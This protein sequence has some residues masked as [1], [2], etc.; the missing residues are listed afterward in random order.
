MTPT[1][2]TISLEDSLEDALMKMTT[3]AVLGHE[4]QGVNPGAP[5]SCL[6]ISDNHVGSIL[7]DS[8]FRLIQ[9]DPNNNWGCPF[10]IL[11]I[12]CNKIRRTSTTIL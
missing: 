4:F 6:G 9:S 2:I 12:W 11:A 7:I 8:A 1:A 3:M 10:Y 5:D